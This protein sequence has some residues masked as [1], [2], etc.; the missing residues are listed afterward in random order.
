MRNFPRA[1]K[2]RLPKVLDGSCNSVVLDCMQTGALGSNTGEEDVERRNYEKEMRNSWEAS[3]WKCLG[4][5]WNICLTFAALEGKIILVL[6]TSS[7]QMLFVCQQGGIQGLMFVI[8]CHA[9]T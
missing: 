7:S 1:Q 9:G 8:V 4:S 3:W 6:S 2:E 5:R